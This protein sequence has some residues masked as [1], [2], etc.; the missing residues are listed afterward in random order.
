M[1]VCSGPG[2]LRAVADSVRF[3]PACKPTTITTQDDIKDH[4]TGY[5]AEL[6]SV[7]SSPRWQRVRLQVI[8]RDPI[9]RRCDLRISTIGDH[10]VPAEVA[11]AQV[12]ASKRFPGDKYAGYFLTSNLQGLCRPCHGIK[13]LEDKAHQ[14]DWPDVLTKYD[15]TPKRT[16]SF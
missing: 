6:H 1:R 5:D 12:R 4:V 3:C 9:C 2:C 15:A 8:K 11:V 14:G 16:Y 13:T 10:I 7:A